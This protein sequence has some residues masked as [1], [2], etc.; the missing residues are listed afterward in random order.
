MIDESVTGQ[1]LDVTGKK[2]SYDTEEI[3]V[4]FV[5]RYKLG[6]ENWKLGLEGQLGR[7]SWALTPQEAGGDYALPRKIAWNS[8]E[9]MRA[10][11]AAPGGMLR[12]SISDFGASEGPGMKEEEIKAGPKGAQVGTGE[13]ATR[14]RVKPAPLWW[15]MAGTD[16]NTGQEYEDGWAGTPSKKM[17]S[18]IKGPGRSVPGGATLASADQLSQI[19]DYES[20]IAAKMETTRP[21]P[22][23][24]EIWT[25]FWIEAL[26]DKIIEGNLSMGGDINKYEDFQS[27]SQDR[28][29]AGL[30]QMI[31][32]MSFDFGGFTAKEAME[33]AFFTALID[34]VFSTAEIGWKSVGNMDGVVVAREQTSDEGGKFF[35][36]GITEA[37][38]SGEDMQQALRTAT[39]HNVDEILQNLSKYGSLL[40][41]VGKIKSEK[42]AKAPYVIYDD[43]GK[44]KSYGK[45]EQI[46]YISKQAAD[47]AISLAMQQFFGSGKPTGEGGLYDYFLPLPSHEAPGFRVG[48]WMGQIRL[49]PIVKKVA[50]GKNVRFVLTAINSAT[51]AYETGISESKHGGVPIYAIVRHLLG[52]Y[53]LL[54]SEIGAI[55]K[56]ASDRYNS[57]AAAVSGIANRGGLFYGELV[58]SYSAGMGG[59]SAE[60]N[61]VNVATSAE[62]AENIRGQIISYFGSSGG[63]EAMRDWFYRQGKRM[64]DLTRAWEERKG[65]GVAH[66]ITARKKWAK[67]NRNL[68]N[69]TFSLKDGHPFRVPSITPEGGS[70]VGIPYFLAK[71]PYD[72]KKTEYR[73]PTQTTVDN[74][75]VNAAVEQALRAKKGAALMTG[76]SDI[77]IGD[78]RR[79]VA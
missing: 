37:L 59:A 68:I 31:N 38:K 58:D 33:Q 55:N 50:V 57:H 74:K 60:I 36:R 66:V 48:S 16:P 67:G 5:R 8:I 25:E 53:P 71:G 23:A 13:F 29:E 46:N 40:E 75:S 45:F 19:F 17:G 9:A 76:R 79:V 61:I 54:A 4:G 30:L 20:D 6:S 34:D 64:K 65:K 1:Y 44:S 70:L 21:K 77:D 72:A 12:E 10:G 18:A 32:Q 28:N 41:A 26:A 24:E 49:K 2:V 3:T 14:Y 7:Y 35:A 43:Q 63:G 15:D 22:N 69:A 52:T 11:G 73:P 42:P 51:R 78:G 47:R 62:V 27:Q 56:T 39:G